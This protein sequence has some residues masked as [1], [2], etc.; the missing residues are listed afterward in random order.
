MCSQSM[1]SHIFL[2]AL[3]DRNNCERQKYTIKLKP[4][5]FYSSDLLPSEIKTHLTTCPYCYP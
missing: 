2:V 1:N 3:F 5:I 4:K